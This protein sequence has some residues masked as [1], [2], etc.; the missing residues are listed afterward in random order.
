[1]MCTLLMSMEL[2]VAGVRAKVAGKEEVGLSGGAVWE[3]EK[4]EEG[5]GEESAGRAAAEEEV[6]LRERLPDALPAPRLPEA[7][8]AR[9]SLLMACN[10][11]E[12]EQTN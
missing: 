8:L 10:K 2:L 7:R 5:V 9:S 12:H 3:K 4:E 6:A 11:A 1:M